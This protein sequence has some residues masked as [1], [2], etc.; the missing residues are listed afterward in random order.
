M[1]W[2]FTTTKKSRQV[3]LDPV[4]CG[5]KAREELRTTISHRLWVNGREREGREGETVRKT[6]RMRIYQP[7]KMR[8][9]WTS[10]ISD[11]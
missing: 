1:K 2:K 4:A 9:L 5:V 8:R 3:K 10:G 7:S 11:S 6:E